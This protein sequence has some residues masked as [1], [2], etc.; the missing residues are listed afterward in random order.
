VP[1]ERKNRENRVSTLS[2]KIVNST[3][4]RNFGDIKDRRW[5]PTIHGVGIFLL[6]ILSLV[7]SVVPIEFLLSFLFLQKKKTNFY[8]SVVDVDSIKDV[9]VDVFGRT[10][11]R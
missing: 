6:Y 11:R 5:C 2:S 9:I 10:D 3:K 4:S 8:M 1:G 7:S